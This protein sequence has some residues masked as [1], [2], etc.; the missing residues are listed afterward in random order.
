MRTYPTTDVYDLKKALTSLGTG[1][2][3]VTVLAENGAPTPVAWTRI[4]PPRSLMDTIGEEAIR[5]AAGSS[6]RRTSCA[7]S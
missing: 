1:E 4:R 5:S 2:A 7:T 6:A 3:I